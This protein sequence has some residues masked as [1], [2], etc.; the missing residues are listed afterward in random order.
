MTNFVLLVA[1]AAFAFATQ[2]DSRADAWIVGV[3]LF[4]VGLFGMTASAKFYERFRLHSDQAR[5]LSEVLRDETGV[6]SLDEL[7]EPVRRRHRVE[8]PVLEKIRLH[9]VW[10]GLH[11]LIA[12]AGLIITVSAV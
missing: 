5:R 11:G 7:L 8:Y 12:L 1:A 4:I 6:P 10:A 3:P 2:L 9:L